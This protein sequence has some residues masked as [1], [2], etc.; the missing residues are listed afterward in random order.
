MSPKFTIENNKLFQAIKLISN[1]LRFRII[2][3]S[4]EKQPTVSELSSSLNLSYNKCA[5]YI[6]MLEKQ[7]LISKTKEGKNIR[8]KSNVKIS[9]NQII[10]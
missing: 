6:R 4:Q 8:I 10:F 9:K 2:E 7:G 5:D 1:Q 3:L